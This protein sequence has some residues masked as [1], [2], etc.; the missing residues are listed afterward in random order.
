MTQE[1]FTILSKSRL[2]S[3]NCY[4]IK[5][6]AGYFLI[7]TGWPNQRAALEKELSRLGC[8]PGNLKLILATHGDFD[9]TGSCAYLHDKFHAKIAMHRGDSAMVEGGDMFINRKINHLS[10]GVLG[11]GTKLLGLNKFDKFAPEIYLEDG[12]ELSGFGLE[13]QVLHVPGHSKGSIAFLTPFS[14]PPDASGRALFCGDLLVNSS[15]PAKNSL[16]DDAAALDTSVERVKLLKPITIYPGHGK[17]FPVELL[18]IV[19]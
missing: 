17:P 18:L 13:A 4:L 15:R 1:I 8:Q 6:E 10:R 14:G 2:G 11:I 19:K 3:V 5:T 7:D 9:H 12:Q 16:V